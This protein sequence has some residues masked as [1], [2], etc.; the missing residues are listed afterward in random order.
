[1]ET[2]KIQNKQS[3]VRQSSGCVQVLNNE[4]LYLSDVVLEEATKCCLK[5]QNYVIRKNWKK[6]KNK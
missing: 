4:D 6:F 3:S 1:L 5:N 2:N